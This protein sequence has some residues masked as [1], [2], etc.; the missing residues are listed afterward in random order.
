QRPFQLVITDMTMPH[1]TGADL[2]R[3]VHRLDATVPVILCT[4]YNESVKA[5]T[6]VRD[7]GIQALLMKPYDLKQLSVLVRSVLDTKNHQARL[8]GKPLNGVGQLP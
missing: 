1:M 5:D 8:D 3:E 7:L 4:G 6:V 2:A